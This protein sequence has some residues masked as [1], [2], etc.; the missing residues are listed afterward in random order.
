VFG[1]RPAP[2]APFQDDE[3]ADRAEAIPIRQNGWSQ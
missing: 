2:D 3:K 1:R